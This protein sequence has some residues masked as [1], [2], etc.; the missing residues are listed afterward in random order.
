MNITAQEKLMYQ[1]MKAIYESGIPVNFKGSMVLKACLMEAGYSEDT[2]HTVDIDANWYSDTPPSAEQMVESLQRAISSSGID[3]KVSIYR[4]YGEGRSAGFEVIDPS[5]E[6]KLFS[7]DIDVNRP[8]VPTKVY[9]VAGLRF[10]G[11]SPVQMIADK[12]AVVSSEKVFRRI[13]DVVDLYYLSAVFDFDRNEVLQVLKNSGRELDSFDGFLN[14][15]EEL[16]HF[17]DKFRFAGDVNKPPFEEV[18]SAVIN[19]IKDVLPL[20]QLVNTKE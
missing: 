2:R 3:L 17:Y 6:E 15:Q 19:Y 10:L 16:K 1:I 4:M 14:R 7:M 18:Y 5:T 12:L 9:E 8:E 20:E 13:K 11:V